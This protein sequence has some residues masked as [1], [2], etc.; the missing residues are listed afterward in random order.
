MKTVETIDGKENLVL[1][2]NQEQ[3]KSWG[4]YKQENK[5]EGQWCARIYIKYAINVHESH[6]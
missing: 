3:K 5:K 4:E 1:W 6:V 2:Q